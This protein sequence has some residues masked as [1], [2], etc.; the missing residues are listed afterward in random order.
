MCQTIPSLMPKVLNRTSAK[1]SCTI[2]RN[3]HYMCE[4]QPLHLIPNVLA[5]NNKSL[6][7]QP[8]LP[9]INQVCGMKV[10]GQLELRCKDCY[11]VARRE[12]LFVMCKTHPRHKQ[13]QMKKR[14]YKTWILTHATQSPRR[15]W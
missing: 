10:K 1:S 6:L 11:Y 15:P 13:T 8:S 9:V 7:A 12:R 4:K 5:Y 14:D 3:F 2:L